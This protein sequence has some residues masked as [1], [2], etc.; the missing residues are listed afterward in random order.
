MS[1]KEQWI[2]AIRDNPPETIADIILN[3]IERIN[4]QAKEIK[5]LNN[6][7]NKALELLIDY[8]LPCEVDDF[9]NVHSDYC[10]THCGVDEE[11]YKRCWNKFIEWKVRM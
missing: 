6:K 11:Q 10:E 8:N 3:D 2:N 5:R 1:G 4:K 7:Y 9:M